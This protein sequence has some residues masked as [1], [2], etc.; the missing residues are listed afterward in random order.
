MGNDKKIEYW[1][2]N[3]DI[4]VDQLNLNCELVTTDIDKVLK[5]VKDEESIRFK[6]Y[7]KRNLKLKNCTPKL[8]SKGNPIDKID[9]LHGNELNLTVF[10]NPQDVTLESPSIS[11][12]IKKIML[13]EEIDFLDTKLN[14]EQTTEQ[15]NSSKI[16]KLTSEIKNKKY[17]L[18]NFDNLEQLSIKSKLFSQF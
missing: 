13:K 6:L 1:D 10:D 3:I 17:L 18:D 12:D 7:N 14:Q 9:R 5:P 11:M 2:E 4:S 16:E 8:D 15:P